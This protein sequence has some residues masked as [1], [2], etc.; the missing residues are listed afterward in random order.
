MPGGTHCRVTR[1]VLL[2]L[3]SGTV[4]QHLIL[5]P[6][7]FYLFSFFHRPQFWCSERNM[8]QDR[9]QPASLGRQV[10]ASCSVTHQTAGCRVC[11]LGRRGKMYCVLIMYY[12]NW[13]SYLDHIFKM[14]SW[15]QEAR[16]QLLQPS[17]TTKRFQLL[18]PR[19]LAGLQWCQRE[20]RITAKGKGE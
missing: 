10:P 1:L 11:F 6:I 20:G 16:F 12:S 3:K 14:E 5:F 17:D 18:Q 19:Y 2:L 15:N 13:N 9:L 4:H 7:H 8:K